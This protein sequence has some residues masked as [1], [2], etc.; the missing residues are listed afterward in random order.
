MPTTEESR[1]FKAYIFRNKGII[2][3]STAITKTY[4]K[5]ISECTTE[6]LILFIPNGIKKNGTNQHMQC[7]RKKLIQFST[8]LLQNQVY[9]I[10]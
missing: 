6:S 4:W 5:N 10:G 7:Q 1:P 2:V 8:R 9:C 3:K